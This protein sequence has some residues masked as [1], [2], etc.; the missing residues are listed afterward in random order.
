MERELNGL[1]APPRLASQLPEPECFWVRHAP[2][3]WPGPPGLWLDLARGR[4]GEPDPGVGVRVEGRLEDLLYL[5][6]VVPELAEER[7]RVAATHLAA[8]TPVLVQLLA[9]D[10]PPPPE[11]VAVHDLLPLL[12]AGEVDRLGELPAGGAAVW[13]LIPGI[14]DDPALWRRGC[15]LLAGAGLTCLQALVP[16]LT[17]MG[18][19]RLA[20]GRSEEVFHA[21]FHRAAPPSRELA[22]VAARHGLAPFLL[23]PLPRP[24]L[25]GAGNRRLA[26]AL[27]LA[28]EIWLSLDRPV[29][30]GLALARAGRWV[31]ESSYDV[32]ALAREGNLGVVGQIDPLSR[33]VIER[34]VEGGGFPLLDELLA[35]YTAWGDET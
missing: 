3:S 11:A 8:G 21:L 5:P 32:A 1:T 18:R 13:P 27:I 23:R 34:W 10:P 4:L 14:S 16:A 9:G 22:R 30:Q 24:P 31:D 28:A 6:P 20:E 29:G 25:L 15:R 19:R 7:R 2:R 33:G 35:E 26:G 12:A 17:P